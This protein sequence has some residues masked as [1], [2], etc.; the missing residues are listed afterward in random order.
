MG[1]QEDI[2]KLKEENKAIMTLLKNPPK[3][4]QTVLYLVES[5][6]KM[7]N[8]NLDLSYKW[9][10]AVAYLRNKQLIME[11][12]DWVA[13]LETIESPQ[14]K[15]IFMLQP[16]GK[17]KEAEVPTAPELCKHMNPHRE[18]LECSLPIAH[19]GDIHSGKDTNDT[20]FQWTEDKDMGEWE[21]K[22]LP[23]APTN[24]ES[25]REELDKCLN[26][27]Q[28]ADGNYSMVCERIGMK[29][30]E[31]FTEDQLGKVVAFMRELPD[32]DAPA[33]NGCNPDN[34]EKSKTLEE[35]AFKR[36]AH[37]METREGAKEKREEAL[38]IMSLTKEDK[39]TEAEAATICKALE[40]LPILT[41]PMEP[42]NPEINTPK[43]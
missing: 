17:P 12:N 13:Q 22:N 39:L 7:E 6:Q 40:K 2:K 38:V 29:P 26:E 1:T 16:I 31:A 14:M 11:Y 35:D 28:D 41:H 23:I 3:N 10:T 5:I 37:L 34:C 25:L 4:A 24:L 33:P 19:G 8:A 30:E 42:E 18:G 36:L 27:K 43:K 15:Q 32:I 20:A 9:N 21:E